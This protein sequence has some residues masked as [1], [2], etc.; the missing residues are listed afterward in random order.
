MES[1]TYLSSPQIVVASLALILGHSDYQIAL[2][3]QQSALRSPPPKT[4]TF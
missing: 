2:D 3:N 1:P 4:E